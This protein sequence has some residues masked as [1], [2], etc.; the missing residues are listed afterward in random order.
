MRTF[1]GYWHLT[2]YKCYSLWNEEELIGVCKV[3][4]TCKVKYVVVVVC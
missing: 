4:V 3:V 2:I 1:R